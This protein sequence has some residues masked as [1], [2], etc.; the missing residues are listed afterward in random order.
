M[1]KIKQKRKE[2]CKKAKKDE[3]KEKVKI[4]KDKIGK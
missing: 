4:Q 2:E 1:Q 3:S